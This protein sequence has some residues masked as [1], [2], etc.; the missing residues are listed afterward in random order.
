MQ[1]LKAL[2][3][4]IRNSRPRSWRHSAAKSAACDDP[5]EPGRGAW[6]GDGG[7][8]GSA[9]SLTFRSRV[10]S[11]RAPASGHSRS[12]W[13]DSRP[14]GRSCALDGESGHQP[15][16]RDA[17][18][19]E[20]PVSASGNACRQRASRCPAFAGSGPES[21][22]RATGGAVT[23]RGPGA[24]RNREPPDVGPIA[25]PASRSSAHVESRIACPG[26][27]ALCRIILSVISG[28]AGSLR[29]WIGQSAA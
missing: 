13:T 25:S 23:S 20:T 24:C 18:A 19:P 5:R 27:R 12:G 10:P 28:V 16:T 15:P 9:R 17:D 4:E 26:Y 7:A 8:S 11:L 22:R 6:P 2:E 29:S 21:L 3:R 14:L 1:D